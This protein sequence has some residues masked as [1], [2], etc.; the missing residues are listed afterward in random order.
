MS[1][2]FNSFWGFKTIS[3]EFQMFIFD[4]LTMSHVPVT[5]GDPCPMLE[6]CRSQV[7]FAHEGVAFLERPGNFLVD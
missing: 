5:T 4:S 2:G 3:A 7:T 1:K 6:E